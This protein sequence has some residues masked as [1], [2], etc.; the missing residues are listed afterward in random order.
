MRPKIDHLMTDI[1]QAAHELILEINASVICSGD[2]FHLNP[3]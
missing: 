2:K 3:S 1:G